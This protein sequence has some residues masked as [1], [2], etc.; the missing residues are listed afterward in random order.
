MKCDVCL[1]CCLSPSTRKRWLVW[2]GSS[3]GCTEGLCKSEEVWFVSLFPL[4]T[5]ACHQAEGRAG[6]V[7]AGDCSTFHCLEEHMDQV[8]LGQT[9][10]V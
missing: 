9:G 3:Q 2:A 6:R 10:V 8:G 5:D 4:L 1:M 7:C